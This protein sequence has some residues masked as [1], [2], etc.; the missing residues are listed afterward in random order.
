MKGKLFIVFGLV[1]LVLFVC[2]D[3]N[4]TEEPLPHPLFNTNN[5]SDNDLISEPYFTRKNNGNGVVGE[6]Y[7]KSDDSNSL[8]YVFRSNGTLTK[9]QNIIT[10]DVF[11]NSIEREN[12]RNDGTFTIESI[13]NDYDNMIFMKIPWSTVQNNYKILVS[14][15]YLVLKKYE[16]S[17]VEYEILSDGINVKWFRDSVFA[18]RIN[19]GKTINSVP[20]EFVAV[21]IT[22][23]SQRNVFIELPLSELY[24]AN[25][26]VYSKKYWQYGFA[27]TE[28][29]NSVRIDFK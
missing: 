1:I 15:N 5:S 8:I 17:P 10:E 16:G 2:C 14:Q 28:Y 21:P 18:V 25:I 9:I 7:Q 6:W 24:W 12:H 11:G 23:N 3:S 13:E 29:Y 4:Q 26:M 19:Y 22:D 20:Q 27:E